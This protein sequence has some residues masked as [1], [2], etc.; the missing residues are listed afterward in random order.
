MSVSETGQRAC[1]NNLSSCLK[2]IL[3]TCLTK[4]GPDCADLVIKSG[5][6]FFQNL[7]DSAGETAAL[8]VQAS[9][10]ANIPSNK[11]VTCPKDFW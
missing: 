8:K 5:A 7:A 6:G 4:D 3:K 1:I 11:E 2:S 9:R 10:L